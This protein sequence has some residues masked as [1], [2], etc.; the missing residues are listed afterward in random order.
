MPFKIPVRKN[1][2]NLQ[3]YEVFL[4]IYDFFNLFIIKNTHIK[5]G[6]DRM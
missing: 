3:N 2:N 6:S 4:H 5:N 1:L